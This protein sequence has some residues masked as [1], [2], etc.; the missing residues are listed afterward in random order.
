MDIG[1]EDIFGGQ[2][3]LTPPQPPQ[4]PQPPQPPQSFQPPQL[5]HPPQPPQQVTLS[6]QVPARNFSG[7]QYSNTQR[8]SNAGQSENKWCSTGRHHQ[9]PINFIENGQTF[10]TCND[11]RAA[12]RCNHANQRAANSTAQ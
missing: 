5:P 12:Q 10:Q 3:N 4:T 1:N 8:P 2:G 7:R 9:P 6:R 11:C